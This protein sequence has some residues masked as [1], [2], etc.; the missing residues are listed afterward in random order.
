MNRDK[1]P[2]QNSLRY[3][4]IRLL[5]ND[6]SSRF[7]IPIISILLSL[8]VAAIILLAMG[9]NPITAF[10][11]FLRGCGLWA[12]PSY[13]GGQN[14]LTD[15]MS[16]LGILTPMML[17]SLGVIIAMKAGLFNI[18]IAGQMLL[19]GFTASVFVGYSGLSAV[20]AKPLV[21]IIGIIVGGLLGAL[22]GFLKYRFNIHEVVTSIMLNYIIS[23]VTGFFI[24]SYYVDIVTR[25][26][27]PVSAASR[28]TLTDIPAGDVKMSFPLGI[29]LA[30]LAVILVK[31]VLDRTTTGFRLKA[32]GLNPNCAQYAGIKVGGNTVLAMMLSGIMGGLAG[33]TYYLGYFNGIVPKDLASLGYDS[34]AVSVLGNVNPIGS[35]FASI[36]ITIFQKGSVYMSSTVGV[37]KE[38]A[39]VVTGILLL[40]SACGGYIRYVAVRKRDKFFPAETAA[41]AAE[42]ETKAEKEGK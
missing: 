14:M 33:V 34:I 36:L 38:I 16:F 30:I 15:F 19:S 2:E 17:A 41:P 32:V 10:L 40:F 37:P 12:K 5:S 27:R 28:L 42:A 24:N 35:I 31:F 3:K 23:Y 8:I 39:S 18:G 13:A 21:V 6:R 25:Q 26:S 4:V 29:F 1:M 9:K 22:T 11:G 7:A 20:I